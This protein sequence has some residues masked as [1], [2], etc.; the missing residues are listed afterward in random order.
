MLGD[1]IYVYKAGQIVMSES[2]QEWTYMVIFEDKQYEP[3]PARAFDTEEGMIMSPFVLDRNVPL[4]DLREEVRLG[5]TENS[6]SI[7]IAPG[8]DFFNRI[9]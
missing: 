4:M 2:G 7:K 9:I 6:R 8:S 1:H 5:R 3:H